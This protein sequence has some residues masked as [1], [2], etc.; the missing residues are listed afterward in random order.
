VTGV[1][2]CAL[3]IWNFLVVEHDAEQRKSILELIG[4][5]DVEATAVGSGES[6]LAALKEKQYD[7]MV[8]DLGL[9]DMSGFELTKR[10]QS[11]QG[12]TDFPV[13]VYAGNQVSKG[14][15][16]E[17]RGSNRGI[18]VNTAQSQERLL[19]ETVLFLQ[20]IEAGMES[21]VAS[22]RQRISMDFDYNDLSLANR[23]VLVI[24]D[25]VRNIFAVTSV[26]ERHQVSVI[27]AENGED[28]IDL[29]RENPDVE[30]IL[31]DVMMPD[32]DGYET[33][34]KIRAI[35]TYRNLPIVA[36]TA[37]A[38]KGD[39]EKCLEAGASDYIAKP[40]DTDELVS[41]L[42]IWL[43]NGRHHAN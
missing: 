29:L 4:D 8:V 14:G 7:C 13:V 41:L 42:R 34:R 12:R 35:E 5:S 43:T 3:P 6:A 18:I 39:R 16:F 31:M 23:K 37:R 38:M 11:V 17:R 28:G 20:R 32:L 26:L 30:C 19:D 25:D 36:L 24:D 40:V 9:P 21:G 15:Q 27:Y 33:M 1:Q 10:V 22:A 2:T